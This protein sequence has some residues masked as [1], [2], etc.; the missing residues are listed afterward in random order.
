[1]TTYHSSTNH[2][3]WTSLIRTSTLS[4]P[5]KSS[6]TIALAWSSLVSCYWQLSRFAMW[7]VTS[8][9]DESSSAKWK[10][11]LRA[12]SQ[13]TW[14][15]LSTSKMNMTTDSYV[16]HVKSYLSSSKHA[17]STW[18]TKIFLYMVFHLNLKTT[19]HPKRTWKLV[20]KGCHQNNTC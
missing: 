2:K 3:S 11:Y 9:R 6:N 4:S 7:G 1:M 14:N 15:S 20:K 8:F 12:L 17:F 13:G 5:V 18:W 10:L 16:R 19:K